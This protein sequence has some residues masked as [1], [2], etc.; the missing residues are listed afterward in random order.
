MNEIFIKNVEKRFQFGAAYHYFWDFTC[1]LI[2]KDGHVIHQ[3][4]PHLLL[5]LVVYRM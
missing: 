4:F 2:T 1:T 5:C 3:K